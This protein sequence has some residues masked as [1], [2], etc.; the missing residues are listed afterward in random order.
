MVLPRARPTPEPPI[1][2][3]REAVNGCS[4][5]TAGGAKPPSLGFRTSLEKSLF[6][7]LTVL[8]W[9]ATFSRLLGATGSPEVRR[10][11]VAGR[12]S[13]YPGPWTVVGAGTNVGEMLMFV[14][15]LFR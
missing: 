11:P 4:G 10:R 3:A 6:F 12:P 15:G 14:P 13:R 9:C 5:K 7:H 8:R 1:A 2:A